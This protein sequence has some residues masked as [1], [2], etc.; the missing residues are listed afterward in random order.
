LKR[1]ALEKYAEELKLDLPKFKKA[2]DEHTHKKAV[3]ADEEAAKKANIMGAPAI[4]VNEYFISGAQPAVKFERVIELAL[5]K[6]KKLNPT[7]SR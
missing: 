3:D 7:V 2:L 5:K 4:S 6:G 1:A